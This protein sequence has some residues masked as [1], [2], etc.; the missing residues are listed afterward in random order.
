MLNILPKLALVAMNTY[1]RV[2]AKVFLP[3]ITPSAKTLKSFSKS[4]KSEASLVTL[5]AL[6]TDI[7]T[8]AAWIAVASLIPSP[9]Y[10]T[11]FFS[12]I[13]NAKIICSFW[14]GSISAKISISLTLFTSASKLI[15][16]ISWPTRIVELNIPI[17]LARLATTYLL[18]PLI[19]L[20]KIPN[21]RSL[22]ID[23]MT[24]FLSGSK[25][26]I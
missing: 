4:T 17:C 20:T 9:K 3:S 19:I 23:S 7:P 24:S 16:C 8:S 11:T 1:F 13:R 14:L 21:L 25:K 22:D 12:E 2:F 6:F 10:P 5:G 15:L 26:T 18:S